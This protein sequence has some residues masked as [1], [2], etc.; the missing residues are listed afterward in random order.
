MIESIDQF[1]SL[2]HVDCPHLEKATTLEWL[3]R[4]LQY[5]KQR[6][7]NILRQGW[8][9]IYLITTDANNRPDQ[10][11]IRES[12]FEEDVAL[13]T[14]VMKSHSNCEEIQFLG[15]R[16]MEYPSHE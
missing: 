3:T 1:G 13:I 14:T 15:L 6:D 9:A 5:F 12:L 7:I 11:P 8:G 10:R 2:Y 4:M 16:A